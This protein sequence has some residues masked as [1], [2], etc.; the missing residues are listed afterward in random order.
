MNRFFTFLQFRLVKKVLN[1]FRMTRYSSGEWNKG[2]D[3]ITIMSRSSELLFW[4]NSV[5]EWLVASST[6]MPDFQTRFSSIA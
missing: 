5:R 1:G 2:C 4:S 6:V 3:S